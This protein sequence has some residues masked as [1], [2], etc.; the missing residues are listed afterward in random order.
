[1]RRRIFNIS[2]LASFYNNHFYIIN[3]PGA[4]FDVVDVGAWPWDHTKCTAD[5][6]VT[7]VSVDSRSLL[8]IVYEEKESAYRNRHDS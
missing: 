1:M 8:L 7:D 6:C 3:D 5:F 2:L 4:H